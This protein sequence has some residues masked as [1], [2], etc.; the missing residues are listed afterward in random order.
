MTVGSYILFL[1]VFGF[2]LTAALGLF[3][4]WVDRKLTARVQYRVGPP[5]L[6]PLFDIVKLMGKEL[7]LPARATPAVFIIAPVV[8]LGSVALT[9]TLLWGNIVGVDGLAFLG[10]L[11]VVL[12]LLVIPS[13]SIIMGGFA[14]GNPLAS[15]GASREMKLVLAYE[16]PFIIAVLVPVIQAGYSIRIGVSESHR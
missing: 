5:L 12:Y 14:S 7:I 15:L 6:Q 10:D 9:S 3:V 16:L 13:L 2:L 8:G 1:M 4:S 11:V